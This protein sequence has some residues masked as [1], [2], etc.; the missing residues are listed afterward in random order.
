LIFAGVFFWCRM[1]E[2]EREGEQKVGWGMRRFWEE[3]GEIKT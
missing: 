1:R 3:L 2:R